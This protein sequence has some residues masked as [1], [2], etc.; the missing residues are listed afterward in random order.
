MK[1]EASYGS[2]EFYI[3]VGA[4]KSDDV[5][6]MIRGKNSP[7]RVMSESTGVSVNDGEWHFIA[8]AWRS[9]GGELVVFSDGVKVFAGGPYRPD[10]ELSSKGAIVLGNL[11]QTNELCV[12]GARRENCTKMQI[13]TKLPIY[14]P[15]AERTD[16]EQISISETNSS[17]YAVA[18]YS[19]E[20]RASDVLEVYQP[21]LL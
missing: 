20:A 8:V 9:A 12:I 2:H 1:G 6:V 7:N 10:I 14:W 16:L 13:C 5:E 3:N 4:S 17:W 19:S 18:L 21:E 11:Q 15:A